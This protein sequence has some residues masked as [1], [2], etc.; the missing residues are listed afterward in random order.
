[1]GNQ[2]EAIGKLGVG[3][4]DF[5]AAQRGHVSHR[6]LSVPAHESDK[7]ANLSNPMAQLAYTTPCVAQSVSLVPDM[8]AGVLIILSWSRSRS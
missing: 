4:G 1:M 2:W 3:G 5:G 8:A 7:L 6:M